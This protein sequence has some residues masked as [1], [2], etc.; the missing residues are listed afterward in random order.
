[1]D[2]QTMYATVSRAVQEQNMQQAYLAQQDADIKAYNAQ[3]GNWKIQ[4]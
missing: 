4:D 3:K 1:M 2:K